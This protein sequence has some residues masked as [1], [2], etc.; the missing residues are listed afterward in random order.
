MTMPTVAENKDLN[1]EIMKHTRAAAIA[2]TTDGVPN[3]IRS[4]NFN[5][6]Y[7]RHVKPNHTA[8]EY[9]GTRPPTT[10]DYP[11][12]TYGSYFHEFICDSTDSATDIQGYR[13]WTKNANGWKCVSPGGFVRKISK[14]GDTDTQFDITVQDEP[15]NVIRYTFDGTGTDPN[16]AANGLRVGERVVINGQNFSTANNIANAIV[17]GVTDDYIEVVNSSGVAEA[18]KTLGTGSITGYLTI[19]SQDDIV[20]GNFAG[21]TTVTIATAWFTHGNTVTVKN[22]GAGALTIATEGSQTIDG[23]ATLVLAQY[24]T[25]TLVSDGANAGRIAYLDAA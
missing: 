6:L 3:I 17:V 9:I 2:A 11:G 22:L 23:A 20:I 12:A 4:V 10:T 16:F 13:L 15:N 24:D 14:F 8:H 25:A 5:G 19:D 21:A 1:T 18:N 7:G